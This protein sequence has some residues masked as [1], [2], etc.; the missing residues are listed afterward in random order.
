MPKGIQ[1]NHH[2]HQQQQQQQSPGSSIL[3]NLVSFLQKFQA[4]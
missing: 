1:N 4:Q 2:H 3:P